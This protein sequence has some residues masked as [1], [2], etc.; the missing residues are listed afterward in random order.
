[1]ASG[2]AFL[3]L[4][5]LWIAIQAEHRAAARTVTE[6]DER[7]LLKVFKYSTR[8]APVQDCSHFEGAPPKATG[9]F[10]IEV[11]GGLRSFLTTAWSFEQLVLGANPPDSV[12]VFWHLWVNSS[13]PLHRECLRV[14]RA[15]PQTRAVVTEEFAD[16][17]EVMLGAIKEM[18]TSSGGD[19]AAAEGGGDA[20]AA[21]REGAL[22]ILASV[23][24]QFVASLKEQTSKMMGAAEMPAEAMLSGDFVCISMHFKVA[25]FAGA[26]QQFVTRDEMVAKIDAL[27]QDLALRTGWG[28]EQALSHWEE[29]KARKCWPIIV[30]AALRLKA[31]LTGLYAQEGSSFYF[32]QCAPP[33]EYGQRFADKPSA[34]ITW[35]LGKAALIAQ[36]E[37]AEASEKATKK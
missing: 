3:R 27:V 21:L 11:S 4:L 35:P 12:D 36:Q 14:I 24:D 1:M 13:L 30:T 6:R 37:L 10:A 19:G 25:L 34:E 17:A 9:R 5:S 31:I 8:P 32:T 22:A 16:R 33:K 20:A 29:G 23:Y 28:W 7:T 15:W 26:T 18:D 2:R